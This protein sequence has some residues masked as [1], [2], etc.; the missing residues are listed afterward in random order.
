MTRNN[1]INEIGNTM[2]LSESQKWY[3]KWNDE[4]I[5]LVIWQWRRNW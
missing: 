5:Q 3:W 1:A 4:E 2:I